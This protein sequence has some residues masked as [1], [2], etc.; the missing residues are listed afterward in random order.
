VG[1]VVD[2]GGL[3][4]SYY[5][6]YG[7][8]PGQRLRTPVVHLRALPGSGWSPTSKEISVTLTGLPAATTT[9]YRLVASNAAGSDSADNDVT[10]APRVPPARGRTTR[11]PPK[12][13]ST[14]VRASAAASAAV[15]AAT[16]DTG[17]LPTSYRLV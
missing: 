2:T 7:A 6:E 13:S 10:T 16:I 5:V 14:L 15:V 4:T 3:P 12:V 11:T 1:A 9:S 17:G 8:R